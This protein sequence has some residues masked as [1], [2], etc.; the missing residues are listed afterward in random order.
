[1]ENSGI[2]LI[3]LGKEQTLNRHS[4]IFRK[5]CDYEKRVRDLEY[6]NFRIFNSDL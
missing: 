3:K 5:V 2:Y 6:D 4:Y 1:M